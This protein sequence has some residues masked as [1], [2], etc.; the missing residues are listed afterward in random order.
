MN[1]DTNVSLLPRTFGD[2]QTIQ[3]KLVSQ[4]KN[5]NALMYE[6]IRPKAVYIAVKYL[7]EQELYNDEGI[8][9]SNDWLNQQFSKRENLIVNDEDRKI[10]LEQKHK[11]FWRWKQLESYDS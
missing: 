2:T 1:V 11:S 4:M 10:K 8:V 9:I 5:K 7:V 3:L 6:T